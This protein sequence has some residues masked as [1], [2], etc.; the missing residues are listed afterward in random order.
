MLL[1]NPL[2]KRGLKPIQRLCYLSSMTFWFFPLPRLMFMLAP[3]LHIFF[4]VKIFV[5]SIDEALAFTATYVVANMMMQNYLYGHVRWPWISELYEYVQGVYLAKSIASVLISPRKPSF[6]VTNKGVSLERD[7]L[8]ALAWPFFAIFGA[9]AAGCATATWRYLFEPGVTS[10]MLVV[11]LWCLFNLVIAG[12]ALGVVA[13]RRQPER[14]PSLPVKRDARAT[15]GNESFAVAIER[16]AAD[17]CSLRRADGA[18][19]PTSAQTGTDG[20]LAVERQRLR[21]ARLPDA[22]GDCG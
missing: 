20:I 9:L 7:H 2:F 11:G 1:K 13:E 18:A 3:L 10:L 15:L 12:A 22:G 17:G 16:S 14:C 4:D 21:A 8:S 6:N 19:W 5:S